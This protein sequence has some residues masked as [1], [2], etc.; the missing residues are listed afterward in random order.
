MSNPG[1]NHNS[2][3]SKEKP[4]ALSSWVGKPVS[5]G[6]VT[7]LSLSLLFSLLIFQRFQ[8]VMD[9]NA[10]AAYEIVNKS[11]DKL[12]ET[13]AFSL[14]AAKTLTYF[15][16]KNGHVNNFDTIA[17]QIIESGINIDVLQL[18]PDGIIKYVYPLQGN[19]TVLGYNILKDSATSKEAFK[20]IEKK[21]MFFAGP[22]KLRQ[23]GIGI[24][25]RLPVY[26]NN[27][28]WGFSA[29]IIRLSTLLKAAG[30]D[31]AAQD[32]YHFQLSKINPDTK[33]TEF[34][35]PYFKSLD[36]SQ[37]VS[38]NV[39]NGEWKLSVTPSYALRGFGDIIILAFLGFLFSAFAGL[40]VWRFALRPKKLN[41]LVLN[42]TLELRISENRYRS[43]IER[44]SDAFIALD[45]NG[46]YTYVNST[47]GEILGYES[48]YLVGKNMWE[49]FPETTDQSFYNAFH[50]AM[51][52]QEYMY[53][54][55][56]SLSLN[57]WLENHFYPS[58]DGMTIFFKDVSGVKE[59][60]MALKRNEEKYQNL[61][62]QA[63]DGIVITNLEGE[64]L[65]VNNSIVQ[66][67]GF[68]SDELIGH[69]ITEYLP[70]NDKEVIPLRINEL[71]QGKSLLY[72]RRLLKK[73]GAYLNVEI[74]SKMATTHTLIGFIRDITIRKKNAEIL[75][76]QARL[77][78]E[79]SDAVTSLDMERRI[80]SWNNA[81]TDL[82]GFETEEVLGKR[83]PEL[84]SF[85][86]RN[87][88]N[89]EVFK[90]V[91]QSGQWKGE[92][93]FIHPKTKLQIDLLSSISSLKNAEGDVTGFIITSKD[94]TERKKGEE[95]VRRSNE[96]FELIAEGTNDAVWDH[97]YAKNET[98]GN[99][100]LR[101]IY[102]LASD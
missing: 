55:E 86:Y 20:A 85:R 83:I 93:Y 97:D 74:N 68:G 19:E 101:K 61:I 36:N 15:I 63:S 10:K 11:R 29:V 3:N 31:S 91:Y 8:L 5:L 33:K 18:V 52:S 57:K 62:E 32:G 44:V 60:A 40:L 64:I 34:F 67:I 87:T 58:E 14:S 84:V 17:A 27:K 54:E 45:K 21:E 70:E 23:G 95:N 96:R 76:Y 28:F 69:H 38:V 99:N 82:Y 48:E 2:Q 102:G 80:V 6:I 47:A 72:E 59:A 79:V 4:A 66:M 73:D 77:L 71:M 56:Y 26:R 51:K 13:L 24:V 78:S 1:V 43:V 9:E 53:L 16:D 94:I 92:F 30:I 46:N 41:E 39:P 65:E 88:N 22:F 75:K 98:W 49:V 100:K 7:F 35:L 37:S 50:Q 12:Q 25:G 81:C 90:Q 42:R 89:E